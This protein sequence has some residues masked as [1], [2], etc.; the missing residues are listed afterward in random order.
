MAPSTEKEPIPVLPVTARA[1]F[2]VPGVDD[3]RRAQEQDPEIRATIDFLRSPT[4][5][6]A[7]PTARQMLR[8]TGEI[9]MHSTSGLLIHSTVTNG[10]RLEVPILP[11]A[12]RNDVLGALHT[13]PMAAHLGVKKTLNKVR[14]QY[15]WKGMTTDVKQF[16]RTCEA[17][18]R[19][20]TVQP[21]TSGELQQ[22]SATQPFEVVGVDLLGPLPSTT[23]GHTYIVVMVD[24]FTRW[25][26]LVPV[27]DIT[28]ATVAKAVVDQLILRHGCPQRLLSDRGSQFRSKLMRQLYRRLGIDKIYTSAYHPQTN[29]QV[30]RFNRVITAALSAYVSER[31]DDWDDYI[32]AIAF[33]YRTSIVDAIGNTPFYLV[34]GGDP[35]L[36]TSA[37][38]ASDR[39]VEMDAY[40]YG[41]ALTERLR[42]AHRL[43]RGVQARTDINRKR[44][45]DA[46][47]QHVEFDIGSLVLVRDQTCK[48]GLSPKLKSK[49]AGPYRVI[50]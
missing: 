43:A 4:G 23:R 50:E 49:Y 9:K 6:E 42:E 1:P 25:V 41:L 2:K 34:Y 36:P 38:A 24:R 22:F 18:Q 47:H 30:E 17:C 33:A 10:Q 44:T 11:A 7:P 13:V 3:L 21:T 15:Y 26:E 28:A 8:D 14:T 39:D 37:F 32:E 16:V 12:L 20:K 29:G 35:L 19:R 45:Y 31:Q 46:T 5:Q 40:R 48:I 27:G